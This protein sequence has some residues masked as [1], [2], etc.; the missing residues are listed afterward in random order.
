MTDPLKKFKL[1]NLKIVS[2]GSEI[3]I[4]TPDIRS[5]KEIAFEM[6]SRKIA[7]SKREMQKLVEEDYV[8]WD[9]FRHKTFLKLSK[10]SKKYRKVKK[11][12][13][14]IFQFNLELNEL[15]TQKYKKNI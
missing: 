8:G 9:E 11:I 2:H 10:L 6:V 15:H 5:R 4:K 13:S 12:L 14:L 1:G 3:T 7:H